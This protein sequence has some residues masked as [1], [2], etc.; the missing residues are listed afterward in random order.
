MEKEF[1][2]SVLKVIARL[3]EKSAKIGCNNASLFGLIFN[4]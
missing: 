1:K 3:G 4:R 2:I